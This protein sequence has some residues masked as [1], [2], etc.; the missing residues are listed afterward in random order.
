[1]APTPPPAFAPAV[2]AALVVGRPT[3]DGGQAEAA[4]RIVA[5]AA[6]LL[7]GRGVRAVAAD[8]IIEA[9][10]VTKATFYRH[11]PT[12]DDVVVVYLR[13]VAAAERAT[14]A[15]WRARHPTAPGRVLVAYAWSLGAQAHGPDFR[16]CPFLNALAAHPE[17]AHPV[18]LA[19]EEHRTWLRGQARDLLDDLGLARPDRIAVQLVMLRDGAMAAGDDVPAAEVRRALLR[20]GAAVVAAGRSARAPGRPTGA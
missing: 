1:M 11:F 12:K 2:D 4:R 17:P 16:G 10:G 20:A 18:H 9:A 7:Y 6:P 5:A 14:V 8:A 13:S 3:R 19:A 15:G